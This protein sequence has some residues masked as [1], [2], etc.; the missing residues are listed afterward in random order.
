MAS[1]SIFLPNLSF[2]PPFRLLPDNGSLTM[3]SQIES[4]KLLSC[5]P[6]TTS[7]TVKSLSLPTNYATLPCKG[8]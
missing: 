8:K 7:E 1:Q 3:V 4:D 2:F 5:E 6:L